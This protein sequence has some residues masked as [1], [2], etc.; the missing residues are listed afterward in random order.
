M[1]S[2][3]K[4]IAIRTAEEEKIRSVG[5]MAADVLARVR[6]LIQVRQIASAIL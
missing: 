3:G 2:P 4:R 1:E 5:R 6:D